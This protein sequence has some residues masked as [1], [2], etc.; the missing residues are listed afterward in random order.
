MPPRAYD[1]WF[2]PT[3]NVPEATRSVRH[4]LRERLADAYPHMVWVFEP[5]EVIL[6]LLREQHPPHNLMYPYS[7]LVRDS[8]DTRWVYEYPLCRFDGS[9]VDARTNVEDEQP[10]GDSYRNHPPAHRAAEFRLYWLVMARVCTGH[11]LML[12][13]VR[14]HER[15]TSKK[16]TEVQRML[17]MFVKQQA[18][19]HTAFCAYYKQHGVHMP[20]VDAPPLDDATHPDR[21]PTPLVDPEMLRHMHVEEGVQRKTPPYKTV[22][23]EMAKLTLPIS[24]HH[25][26]VF[27][28]SIHETIDFVQQ[29]VGEAEHRALWEHNAFLPDTWMVGDSVAMEWTAAPQIRAATAVVLR[30]SE[31][32]SLLDRLMHNSH[33]QTVQGQ[34]TD[35]PEGLRSRLWHELSHKQY[36]PVQLNQL[37]HRQM[38]T[39]T[40]LEECSQ[41]HRELVQS[42]EHAEPREWLRQRGYLSDYSDNKLPPI[43]ELLSAQAR[44]RWI[45]AYSHLG[46]M[47]S[48]VKIVLPNVRK[49]QKT[50]R[51]NKTN[52]V[53]CVEQWL[54]RDR[55]HVPS[56]HVGGSMRA[57]KRYRRYLPHHFRKLALA[58]KHFMHTHIDLVTYMTRHACYTDAQLRMPPVDAPKVGY[59]ALDWHGPHPWRCYSAAST[60]SLSMIAHTADFFMPETPTSTGNVRQNRSSGKESMPRKANRNADYITPLHDLFCRISRTFHEKGD[61]KHINWVQVCANPQIFAWVR[62]AIY[63]SL[64]GLYDFSNVVVPFTTAMHIHNTLKA[65]TFPGLQAEHL[66]VW[67]IRNVPLVTLILQIAMQYTLMH[68]PTVYDHV[69]RAFPSFSTWQID[70]RLMHDSAILTIVRTAAE[71]PAQARRFMQRACGM[72]RLQGIKDSSHKWYFLKPEVVAQWQPAD[73]ERLRSFRRPDL[74]TKTVPLPRG[75]SNKKDD[76]GT[77]LCLAADA[78]DRREAHEKGEPEPEPRVPLPAPAPP[79]EPTLVRQDADLDCLGAQHYFR[80]QQKSLVSIASVANSYITVFGQEIPGPGPV[81]RDFMSFVTALFNLYASRRRNTRPAKAR[82]KAVEPK[83][84][85]AEEDAV[86]EAEKPAPG[87]LPA[88]VESKNVRRMLNLFVHP[89]TKRRATR[90][91]LAYAPG[92]YVPPL[93]MTKYGMSEKGCLYVMCKMSAYMNGTRMALN[94]IDVLVP[95]DACL[96]YLYA[97][98][99]KQNATAWHAPV[100]I[101]GFAHQ[102]AAMMSRCLG[103][104]P[105]MLTTTAFTVNVSRDKK[106][107][108]GPVMRDAHGS[109]F[110][111]YCFVRKQCFDVEASEKARTG[112][113][114][115]CSTKLLFVNAYDSVV[116]LNDVTTLRR[117]IFSVDRHAFCRDTDERIRQKREVMQYEHGSSA[118]RLAQLYGPWRTHYK[119]P[120]PV[121]VKQARQKE[122]PCVPLSSLTWMPCCGM[123]NTLDDAF[124]PFPD[125]GIWCKYCVNV[126]NMRQLLPVCYACGVPRSILNLPRD[127]RSYQRRRM[128]YAMIA[129]LVYNPKTYQMQRVFICNECPSINRNKWKV[130]KQ[131]PAVLT[132]D[133]LNFV[134][135]LHENVAPELGLGQFHFDESHQSFKNTLMRMLRMRGF[136]N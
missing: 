73:R 72:V 82:K 109:D 54:E 119:I 48:G 27:T 85:E 76:L 90:N 99:I 39:N 111:A 31:A 16:F 120:D 105:G 57:W 56:P 40:S 69:Q 104:P 97:S 126:P 23:D 55:M 88:H 49:G 43:S 133:A 66:K 70:T 113:S 4:L 107:C 52:L 89:D 33:V 3:V 124:G 114:R 18:P 61:G 21:Q 80:E 79:P 112:P 58:L 125:A 12:H 96:L 42:M 63:C 59:S 30:L 37:L 1:P 9:R 116:A 47:A 84:K 103:I 6:R 34:H 36:T 121:L 29:V 83:E 28:H 53:S 118:Q 65:T 128:P 50:E 7:H 25:R 115:A 136:T 20:D 19:L 94:D 67:I 45:I 98:V 122:L 13:V 110:T 127:Q 130:L 91:L 101:D 2:R 129:P 81:R 11:Y 135:E 44:E 95:G 131:T 92:E 22:L 5:V 117:D 24:P 15:S 10:A 86:E 75:A 78:I 71:A 64:M 14:N 74:H 32:Y 132:L 87:T 51:E 38:S 93:V 26:A 41:E 134:F 106:S 60:T 123:L 8:F 100:R 62:S 68:T 77:A 46:F 17:T 108:M 35:D 102:Q